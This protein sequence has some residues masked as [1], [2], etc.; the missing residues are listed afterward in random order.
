MFYFSADRG[1][2]LRDD[3][4]TKKNVELVIP[5][6]TRGKPQLSGEEVEN[7]RKIANVRIHIE[8]VI[9]LLRRRFTILA[10]VMPIKLVQ[11][12]V[13]ESRGNEIATCDK[14]V[15]VCASLVNLSDPI[16]RNK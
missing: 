11:S 2:R 10:G 12:A 9:G 4:A 7:S 14:I 16:V 8:R 3:F 13:L 1:F 15:R 5:A 6:F